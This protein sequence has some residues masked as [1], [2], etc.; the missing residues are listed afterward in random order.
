MLV[1]NL[2]LKDSPYWTTLFEQVSDLEISGCGVV[3]RRTGAEAHGLIDITAFNTDGFDLAGCRSP[4][5]AAILAVAQWATRRLSG[6]T[7][8]L[9][10][11][12]LT[13]EQMPT[14]F[15]ILQLTPDSRC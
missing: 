6:E 10:A 5:K 11:A 7:S 13:L 9:A 12:L 3:A 4:A 1:E 14:G 8:R 2:L 15:W